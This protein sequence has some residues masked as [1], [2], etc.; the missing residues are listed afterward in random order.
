MRNQDKINEEIIAEQKELIS[1]L[2]AEI[3][4]LKA[5]KLQKEV[6]KLQEESAANDRIIA[7]IEKNWDLS[8]LNNKQERE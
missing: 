4:L 2:E 7:D 1:L 8:K 6:S 3:A 5:E